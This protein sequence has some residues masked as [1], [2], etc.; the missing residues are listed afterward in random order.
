M[1]SSLTASQP[2]CPTTFAMA[3][4]APM[5]ANHSTMMRTLK[6]SFC[7]IPTPRT[8]D[9]PVPPRACTA[10]PT[11]SATNSVCSTLPEVSAENM[12]SGT[13]DL[14]KCQVPPAA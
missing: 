4:K 6:T 1:P 14:M 12:V 8:I 9:S 2:V 7:S 3:P 5:G 11:N 10:K 13:I